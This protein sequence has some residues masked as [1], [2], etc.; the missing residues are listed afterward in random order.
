MINYNPQANVSDESCNYPNGGSQQLALVAGWNM[1]SSFIQTENM[2]VE[3][4]M[5]P[6]LSQVIIVKDNL[7]LHIFRTL[8]LMELETGTIHRV[9][10]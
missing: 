10:N 8:V 9:I 3:A 7:G 6:I 1:A 2:S 4:I 5:E